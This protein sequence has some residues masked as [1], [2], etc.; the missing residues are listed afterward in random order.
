MT[1]RMIK[2]FNRL[3]SFLLTGLFI[4]FS[5]FRKSLPTQQP[6]LDPRWTANQ[7]FLWQVEQSKFTIP[8]GARDILTG[9]LRRTL[10]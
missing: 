8:T 2:T 7:A 5:V 10:E 4:L 6:L 1:N 9:D 3:Y